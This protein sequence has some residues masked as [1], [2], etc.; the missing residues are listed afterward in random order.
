M[1][2]DDNELRVANY[3]KEVMRLWSK[4]MGETLAFDELANASDVQIKALGGNEIGNNMLSLNAN[5]MQRMQR[6]QSFTNIDIF[7]DLAQ[8]FVNDAILNFVSPNK[9]RF[10]DDLVDLTQSILGVSRLPD[11]ISS[12]INVSCNR[13]GCF[14]NLPNRSIHYEDAIGPL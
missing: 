8:G 7:L 11:S 2:N 4:S 10:I 9:G 1:F 14:Y 6:M 5:V 12:Q 13:D 3:R